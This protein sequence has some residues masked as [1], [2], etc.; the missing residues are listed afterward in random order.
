MMKRIVLTL[1]TLALVQALLI[2]IPQKADAIPPFMKE[3]VKTYVDEESKDS[4]EAAFAKVVT[5]AKCHVCHKGKSKKDM[6]PYGAEL[7]KL[8]DKKTD[9]KDIKKI[10]AALEKVAAM[11]SDTK[12]EKAPTFGDLIKEHK[13]PGGKPDKG[14]DET[15]AAK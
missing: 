8:L 5:E 2:A 9:K 4:Q 12:D 11:K 1:G 3:F 10:N 6:N 7:K 13:L 14:T 15:H